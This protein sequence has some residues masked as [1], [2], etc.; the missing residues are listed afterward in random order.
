MED[1]LARLSGR[2]DRL[3]GRVAVLEVKVEEEA[4]LRANMDSDLG[5]M[6]ATLNAHTRSLQAL[7]DT[8]SDH[9]ARLTR[10]EDRLDG[11]E[12]RLDGVEGR[13][14]RVDEG[15]TEVRTGLTEVRT[16]LGNVQIGVHA[17]IDLLDTHLARK[18]R[19]PSLKL[20][21]PRSC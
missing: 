2:Q 17:I 11:V 13:L 12:D 3:E 10:I 16:G 21:R 4:A 20:R 5:D 18:P 7:A 19:W 6:K 14:D 8:Q 15:L 9:T 1:D